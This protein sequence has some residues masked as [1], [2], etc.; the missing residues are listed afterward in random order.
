MPN[1][2]SKSNIKIVKQMSGQ[3]MDN[4]DVYLFFVLD[5]LALRIT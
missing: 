4:S 3:D 5:Y 2:K 1:I